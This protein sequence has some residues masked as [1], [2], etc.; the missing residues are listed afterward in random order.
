[1]NERPKW[2]FDAGA[3][4][5]QLVALVS[6]AFKLNQGDGDV[7]LEETLGFGDFIFE[8]IAFIGANVRQIFSSWKNYTGSKNEG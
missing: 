3:I 5:A 2:Y 7:A 4:A 8:T 1:M 6:V